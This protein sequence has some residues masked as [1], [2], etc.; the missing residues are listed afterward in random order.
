MNGGG[1]AIGAFAWDELYTKYKNIGLCCNLN[2]MRDQLICHVQFAFWRATFNLDEWRP[3]VGYLQ[4]VNS[5]CN[6]GGSKWFD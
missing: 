5:S 3:D 4:T 6:P 2:G 1:Y